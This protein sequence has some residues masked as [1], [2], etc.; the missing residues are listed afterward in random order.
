ML[1]TGVPVFLG[2][3]NEADIKAWNEEHDDPDDADERFL[4]K[5]LAGDTGP[6]IVRNGAI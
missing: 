1:R 3:V 4:C 2:L 6:A 5:R